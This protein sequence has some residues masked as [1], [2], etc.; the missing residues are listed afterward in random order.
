MKFYG[1]FRSSAAYRCRIA[2]A[3]K[4]V[5]PDVLP[6]H[7]RRGGGEQKTADFR[8]V[9]P[10]ALVPAID[11][12]GRILTQSLAIIEWL[13]ETHPLPP[14]LPQ[15]PAERAEV[16]AFALAISADIHPLNNLRV[17]DYLKDPLGHSQDD[18]DAWA[19]HWI[20][21]GLAACERLVLRSPLRGR[22][23]FGDEVTLADLCLVP[24][25]FSA[26]RFKTDLSACPT[27]VEIDRVCAEH[28]A[29]QGARPEAQPD[30]EA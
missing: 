20:H 1:Y 29:F 9:N 14:L 12:E 15:D 8:G 18:I 23:C 13:N 4:S 28:P 30:A 11:I 7:L 19:R 10:Q 2:F 27:L 24:Q 21:D 6:V 26:R 16:R 5:T 25:L 17:L 22:Y 3:I